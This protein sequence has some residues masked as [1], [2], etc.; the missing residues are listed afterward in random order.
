MCFR[1]GG[2]KLAKSNGIK[3]FSELSNSPLRISD[4]RFAWDRSYQIEIDAFEIGPRERDLILGPS[5]SGKSTL[6][7][8]ISGITKVDQGK[9]EVLGEDLARLRGAKIDRFRADKLGIIFQMFNLL[10]WCSILENVLLPLRFS[11]ARRLRAKSTPDEAGRLLEALGLSREFHRKSTGTLSVGQQQRVAAARALIGQPA[12]VLAD[13][14]TS[15][16]DTENAQ[17]FL[18]LLV[19]ELES[20]DSALLMV[21]HDTSL[22]PMFDR[23][24]RLDEIARITRSEAA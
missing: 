6:L 16:L 15:A 23:T 14:P 7:N 8:L 20:A 22:A 19:A 21:S 5:G 2:S 24:V 12:L 4:A 10:P 17:A 11:K 1:I 18:R 3:R 9:I 13:E